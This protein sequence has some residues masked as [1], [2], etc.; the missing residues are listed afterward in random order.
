MVVEL[1]RFD[2]ERLDDKQ[3]VG[4]EI[5]TLFLGQVDE[6]AH[7]GPHVVLFLVVADKPSRVAL[8]IIIRQAV[9]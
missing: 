6:E 1:R 3:L 8:E 7:V 9:L 5:G 2:A 4:R